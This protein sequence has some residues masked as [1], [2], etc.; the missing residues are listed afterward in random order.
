MH[1]TISAL[2]DRPHLKGARGYILRLLQDNATDGV[3]TLSQ[4]AISTL[5]G[6]CLATVKY[7]LGALV[8]EERIC[9]TRTPGDRRNSY[10]VR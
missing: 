3:C 10:R 1:A 6:Y 4:E 9:I 8:T 7:T 2:T 5:T